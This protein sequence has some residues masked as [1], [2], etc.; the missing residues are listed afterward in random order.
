[1]V[2]PGFGG[3]YPQL[4][5][6]TCIFLGLVYNASQMVSLVGDDAIRYCLLGP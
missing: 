2:L 3:V 6:D 1:M 5:V 4:L